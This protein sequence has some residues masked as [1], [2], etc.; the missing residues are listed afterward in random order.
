MIFPLPHGVGL[1]HVWGRG[2]QESDENC[3]NQYT[4]MSSHKDDDEEKEEDPASREDAELRLLAATQSDNHYLSDPTL[5]VNAFE[6]GKRMAKVSNTY[7]KDSAL[8][9]T[10]HR[11][12]LSLGRRLKRKGAMINL[13][14]S[15]C[16]D[17]S[18]ERDSSG[19][20]S[21]VKPTGLRKS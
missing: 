20:D 13:R 5:R 8:I 19:K 6:S 9:V 18:H 4:H 11:L 12:P 21:E 2:A 16:I 7:L 15:A 3:L 10:V 14:A 1:H 17:P